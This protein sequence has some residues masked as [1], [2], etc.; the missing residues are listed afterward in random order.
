MDFKPSVYTAS[1]FGD[2]PIDLSS[3]HVSGIPLGARGI[4]GHIPRNL[5]E[6]LR[7]IYDAF[8]INEFTCYDI[9]NKYGLKNLKF[10]CT[11]LRTFRNYGAV[12]FTTKR[13]E[14]G[15]KP[16]RVWKLTSETINYFATHQ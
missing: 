14:R 13:V 11:T 16:V 5:R 3:S 6:T 15:G 4:T 7:K 1:D 8:W 10:K 12:T 9:Q 2:E